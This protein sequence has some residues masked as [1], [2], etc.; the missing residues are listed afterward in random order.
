MVVS[1]FAACGDDSDGAR[2]VPT[3]LPKVGTLVG[4]V[5]GGDLYFALISD[6]ERV[7]G[8]VC[9]DGGIA[10][11]LAPAEIDNGRAQL[12]SRDGKDMGEVE[13][14]EDGASGSIEVAGQSLG[15]D[16]APASGDAG[17]FRATAGAAGEAGSAEV[18]WIKL[19]DGT[20]KGSVKTLDES[21]NVVIGPAPELPDGGGGFVDLGGEQVEVHK[22][23]P[24]FIE[25]VL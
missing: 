12:V 4:A 17:V 24:E 20:I 23:G 22:L 15:F 11:W 6:G 5:D 14:G 16:V 18:G 10:A 7:V 8:Y 2:T 13:I 19:P 1:C 3:P 9:D 21:G 25:S